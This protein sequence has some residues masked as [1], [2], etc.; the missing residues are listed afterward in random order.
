L[1]N[2]LFIERFFQRYESALTESHAVGLSQLM[3]LSDNDLLDLLLGR[4][5]PQG[6]VAASA[7][8]LQVLVMLRTP[9]EISN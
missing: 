5:P 2:D 9:F 8:A 6:V 7:D 1:E 4:Q 3:D